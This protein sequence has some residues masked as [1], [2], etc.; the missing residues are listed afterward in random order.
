V[1]L[2]ITEKQFRKAQKPEQ[3]AVILT[4][5]LKVAEKNTLAGMLYMIWL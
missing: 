4:D 2:K 1:Q 3:K 5:L